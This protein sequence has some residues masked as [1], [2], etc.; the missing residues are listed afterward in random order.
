MWLDSKFSTARLWAQFE[1][2]KIRPWARHRFVCPYHFFCQYEAV[3][4]SA[5]VSHIRFST[6]AR[7][8]TCIPWSLGFLPFLL[9]FISA[10]ETLQAA[11]LKA[12]VVSSG[13]TDGNDVIERVWRKK[14]TKRGR[15]KTFNKRIIFSKLTFNFFHLLRIC[16]IKKTLFYWTCSEASP[17]K[18]V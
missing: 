2:C 14:R 1:A 4:I 17:V 16:T 7:H 10:E 9:R 11:A 5:R 8:H 12:L 6:A 15:Q 13:S 18:M 3:S